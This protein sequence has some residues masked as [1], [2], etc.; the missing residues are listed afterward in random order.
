MYG[1]HL[2]FLLISFAAMILL[3]SRT[4][5][6]EAA[7]IWAFLWQGTFLLAAT[8]AVFGGLLLLFE[9]SM[10]GFLKRVRSAMMN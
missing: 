4:G 6:G 1:K 3:S 10:R 5:L 8:V 2:A 9:Q 7:S